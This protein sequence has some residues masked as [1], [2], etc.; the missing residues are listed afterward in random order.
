MLSDEACNRSFDVDLAVT[1]YVAVEGSC[2]E[3]GGLVRYV[4]QCFS[5]VCGSCV[6]S[7]ILL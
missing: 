4:L 2:G 3:R 1:I 6:K 7:V 5:E